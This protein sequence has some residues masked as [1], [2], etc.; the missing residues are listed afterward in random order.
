[1]ADDFS[2]FFS[3]ISFGL[4]IECR[5]WA[6]STIC[7]FGGEED[8]VTFGVCSFCC[9]FFAAI[10]WAYVCSFSLGFDGSDADALYKCEISCGGFAITGFAGDCEN[11][12]FRFS[13]FPVDFAIGNDI[14]FSSM[15]LGDGAL[16]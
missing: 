10:N 11:I 9:T 4:G 13:T 6:F 16:C 3:G 1:M 15:I 7:G 14:T 12:F 8:N 2:G 5:G